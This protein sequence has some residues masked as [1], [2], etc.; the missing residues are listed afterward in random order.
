[1]AGFNLIKKLDRGIGIPI[2][3]ILGFFKFKEKTIPKKIKKVLFIRLGNIGDAILTI[4]TLREFQRN[5][6]KTKL[7]VLT[8]SRTGR[9]YDNVG[10]IDNLI[11]FNIIENNGVF[12]DIYENISIIKKLISKLKKK[13]FDLIIDMETYS[14]VTPLITYFSKPRFSISFDSPRQHRGFIYDKKIEYPWDRHEVECFLDLIRILNIKIKNKNLEYKFQRDKLVDKL[15]SENG[16][17]KKDKFVI[18]H[19]GCNKDWIIKEWP[20]ERFAEVMKSII[21]RYNAKIILTGG[22]NDFETNEEI[23]KLAKLPEEAV[24]NFAGKL[25]IH[26]LAYLISKA[27]LYVGNDTGP[28]H[29]SASVQTP[30]IGIFGPSTPLKWGPYG[31]KHLGVH[32]NINQ[33]PT[34]ILG[35]LS[36]DAKSPDVS[37]KEVMN[38]IHRRL[39]WERRLN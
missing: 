35:K 3:F 5:F 6:P 32:S 4:P 2:N 14:R 17:S 28:M 27:K 25:N 9:I 10:Y 36:K 38:E 26:Q 12:K 13:K 18:V 11:D 22:Q 8:S 20:R 1:M 39:R 33:Y 37:T 24:F 31:K 16:I 7:Y 23:I 30:T 29:L 19:S 34:L 21:K 15:L